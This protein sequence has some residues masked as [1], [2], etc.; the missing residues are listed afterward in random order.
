MSNKKST[1]YRSAKTGRFV[2]E[3]YANKH[4][5]TT[6]RER[7]AKPVKNKKKSGICGKRRPARV[8]GKPSW[9][10]GYKA[11]STQVDPK[12]NGSYTPPWH[13]R[14]SFFEN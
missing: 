6:V 8:S 3:K 5:K 7:I 1:A 10:G 12:P 14:K 4:P 9:A 11:D 2:T 13:K